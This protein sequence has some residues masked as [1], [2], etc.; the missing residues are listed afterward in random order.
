MS[1]EAPTCARTELGSSETASDQTLPATAQNGPQHL[2][3]R[4]E[5]NEVQ[6]GDRL[7][8]VT[9]ETVMQPGF[10]LGPLVSRAHFCCQEAPISLPPHPCPHPEVAR[11]CP[12]PL[13]LRGW[14]GQL[15]W[16]SV[17]ELFW[18]CTLSPNPSPPSHGHKSLRSFQPWTSAQKEPQ[19]LGSCWC[20]ALAEGAF[21][22]NPWAPPAQP[23]A[24]RAPGRLKVRVPTLGS[25]SQVTQPS[26]WIQRITKCLFGITA[27]AA[28]T[29]PYP[30]LSL[31]QKRCW[32][33]AYSAS[34]VTLP[35]L[36]WD[37]TSRMEK[38]K[39]EVADWPAVSQR[40]GG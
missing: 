15:L 35:E 7:S 30:A 25:S 28:T 12:T 32:W 20:V 13:P 34:P 27:A 6:G 14:R 5:E 36:C 10:N 23:A 31:C 8:K 18:K 9:E 17:K 39:L 3:M 11:P 29:I 22:T 2:H 40:G 26:V 38:P 24:P 21:S 37:L 1:A 16:A 19:R 4:G 33:S